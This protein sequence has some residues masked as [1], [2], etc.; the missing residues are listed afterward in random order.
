VDR[1]ARDLDAPG[2][3]GLVH[4]PAVIASAAEGGDQRGVDVEDPPLVIGGDLHQREEAA[5]DDQVGAAVADRT[6]DRG[7]KIGQVP[8]PATTV[9]TP[10]DA[11]DPA[12]RARRHVLFCA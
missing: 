12:H 2:D 8:L 7:A 5:Q 10:P 9:D 1:A 11:S 6:E 4:G 3:G